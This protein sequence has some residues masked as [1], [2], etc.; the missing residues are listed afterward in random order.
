MG[1]RELLVRAADYGR[2]QLPRLLY[3]PIHDPDV[4]RLRGR[5]TYLV[6]FPDVREQNG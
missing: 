5:A 1:V 2:P 6:D 4:A 3:L